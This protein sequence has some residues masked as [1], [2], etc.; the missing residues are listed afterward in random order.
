M[1]QEL[2]A[3][4]VGDFQWVQVSPGDGSLQPVAFGAAEEVTSPSKLYIA[5]DSPE[6]K[7]R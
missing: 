4:K 7:N 3:V 1:V 2:C 5:I 6:A